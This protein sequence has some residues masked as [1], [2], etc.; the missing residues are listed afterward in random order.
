MEKVK[1]LLVGLSIYVIIILVV[2]TINWFFVNPT[3]A[4][5]QLPNFLSS[6]VEIIVISCIASLFFKKRPDSLIPIMIGVLG[7]T[8]LEIPSLMNTISLFNTQ[9]ELA[10][11]IVNQ[12][13]TL[14]DFPDGYFISSYFL[15]NTTLAGTIYEWVLSSEIPAIFINGIFLVGY[16]EASIKGLKWNKKISY[17]MIKFIPVYIMTILN[18]SLSILFP[19]GTL[20]EYAV[21]NIVTIF[22][23]SVVYM[24]VRI[25]KKILKKKSS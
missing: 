2:T 9:K 24:I 22:V 7:S 6:A 4:S 8:L 25:R 11:S 21:I 18:I 15:S 5:E 3:F 19:E 13:L 20:H 1:K 23:L 10:T 16:K 12:P 17:L 14:D